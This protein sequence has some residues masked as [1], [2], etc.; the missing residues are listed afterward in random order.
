VTGGAVVT[1]HLR[2]GL[3]CR[4]ALHC[5]C[6]LRLSQCG[7]ASQRFAFR[8]CACQTCLGSFDQQIAR[9]LRY[10]NQHAHGHLAGSTGQIDPAEGQAMHADSVGRQLLYCGAYIHGISTKPVQFCDDEHIAGLQAV[11][12]SSK[13]RPLS[14]RDAAT[15]VFAHDSAFVDREAGG[16]DLM[17]LV[18]LPITNGLR[19]MPVLNLIGRRD[20]LAP[21]RRRA[22]PVALV[23]PFNFVCRNVFRGERKG[24]LMSADPNI[25]R[26]KILVQA[27][28]PTLVIKAGEKR[29]DKIEA[30]LIRSLMSHPEYPAIKSLFTSMQGELRKWINEATG[31]YQPSDIELRNY[32][33]MYMYNM[34]A[35]A[36]EH[37]VTVVS[38]VGNSF[39][40]IQDAAIAEK[41]AEARKKYE[42]NGGMCESIAC[43]WLSCQIVGN[44]DEWEQMNNP[45][46]HYEGFGFRQH[47]H[48]LISE[49]VALNMK[50]IS[51]RYQKE[52]VRAQ[53]FRDK[54]SGNVFT[55]MQRFVSRTLGHRV[56][57]DAAREKDYLEELGTLSREHFRKLV[58]G[59][60]SAVLSAPQE[61]KAPHEILIHLTPGYYLLKLSGK[62]ARHALA[63]RVSKETMQLIDPN[64]CVWE[65]AH[66]NVGKLV[67]AFFASLNASHWHTTGAW[68]VI[69]YNRAYLPQVHEMIEPYFPGNHRVTELI[70]SYLADPP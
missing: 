69:E 28:L 53:D 25:G 35:L 22:T 30:Q 57:L 49:S 54:A 31:I 36:A 18:F 21:A 1:R 8:T 37:D 65:G 41:Y 59:A 56:P 60:A 4:E 33:E 19:N 64:G 48:G 16:L 15:D 13:L 29:S 52:A 9:E 68:E 23:N 46:N 7:R 17:D 58:P 24:N 20:V 39:L 43:T 50:K 12:Q 27:A 5:V 3:T 66:A 51:D 55:G 70:E 40:K 47:A 67:D 38:L 44:V 26:F 6:L 34:Q 45:E 63:C 62:H 2:N 61:K 11:Q 14:G 10:R 42:S 32:D